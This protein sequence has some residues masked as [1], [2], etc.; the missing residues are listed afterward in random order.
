MG[1]KTWESIPPTKRP[2][3]NRLNVI[4]STN[5]EYVPE[6]TDSNST[7]VYT[8]FEKALEEVSQKSDVNEIFVIGGQA[9]FELSLG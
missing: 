7:V 2:L 1:R 5:P 3:A 8:D 6:N 9:L 4:L